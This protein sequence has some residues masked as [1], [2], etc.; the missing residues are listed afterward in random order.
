MPTA[1]SWPQNWSK[2]FLDRTGCQQPRWARQSGGSMARHKGRR[3]F[4]ASLGRGS[5]SKTNTVQSH[6]HGPW[7]FSLRVHRTPVFSEWGSPRI[8][9]PSLAHRRPSYCSPFRFACFRL[10]VS[11]RACF[12][13]AKR[14]P[15]CGPE[16]SNLGGDCQPAPQKT[17][18]S[19]SG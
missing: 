4:P 6:H 14:L 13:S 18:W 19:P 9:R 8:A 7:R 16:T 10:P 1:W 11:R 5:R 15:A 17:A 3:L 2:W 12:G